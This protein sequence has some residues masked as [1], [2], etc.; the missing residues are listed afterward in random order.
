MC[1]HN[2][3]TVILAAASRLNLRTAPS[4]AYGAVTVDILASASGNHC[5]I[6]PIIT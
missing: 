4:L 1:W 3:R 6:M 5:A 2:D